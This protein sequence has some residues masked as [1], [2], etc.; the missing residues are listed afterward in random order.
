MRLFFSLCGNWLVRSS[1]ITDMRQ[2]SRIILLNCSHYDEASHRR[3]PDSPEAFRQLKCVDGFFR[4]VHA[5]AR[6]H[7][8]DIILC[9]D[10]GH[11]AA[12]PFHHVDGHTFAVRVFEACAP[13]PVDDRFRALVRRMQRLAVRASAFR[14]WHSLLGSWIGR[15]MQQSHTDYLKHLK[16]EYAFPADELAV[17]TCGPTA[18]I[19]VGQRSCEASLEEIEARFPRLVPM[20]AASRAVGLIVARSK[21]DGPV[22]L[23]QGQRI[24]LDDLDSLASLAPF[25]QMGVAFLS[26]QLQKVLSFKTT[27]DLVVYGAFAKAGTISFDNEFGTHGGVHPDEFN[28][29]FIPPPGIDLRDGSLN[30]VELNTILRKRYS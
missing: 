22:V 4:H 25:R 6:E 8:Y 16:Q 15:W 23:F 27:G 10:H 30:P 17:V 28:A 19:Y 20:L 18:H 9:S 26:G 14:K 2:G 13:G 29:F 1:I 7:G 21:K 11:A 3:G 5:T 12:L 24:P